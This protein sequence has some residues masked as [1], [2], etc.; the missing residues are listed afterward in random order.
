MARLAAAAAA[1]L[2]A[3]LLAVSAAGCGTSAADGRSA[4]AAARQQVTPVAKAL[5]HR[6]LVSHASKAYPGTGVYVRCGNSG[7]RLHYSVSLDLFSRHGESLATYRQQVASVVSGDGWKLHPL[8]PPPP[9]DPGSVFYKITK[10]IGSVV[11]VG[12]LAAFPGGVT[13]G[14]GSVVV[15]SVCFDAGPA[16]GDLLQHPIESPLS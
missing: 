8:P 10:P 1:L 4:A 12:S 5:Y 7:T 14:R 11:F 3:A 16:A 6:L 2:A 15:N 9:D 13:P